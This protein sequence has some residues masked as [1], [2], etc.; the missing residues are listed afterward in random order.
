MDKTRDDSQFHEISFEELEDIVAECA[1]VEVPLESFQEF[2]DETNGYEKDLTDEITER[3]CYCESLVDAGKYTEAFNKA[4]ELHTVLPQQLISRLFKLYDACATHGNIGA[5]AVLADH[6]FCRGESSTEIKGQAFDYLYRLYQKGYLP[7]FRDLGYCY[8]HGIGT[9]IDKKKAIT[10]FTKGFLYCGDHACRQYLQ[11]LVPEIPDAFEDGSRFYL[12][13]GCEQNYEKAFE[14]LTNAAI[15]E[16][17]GAGYCF[18]RM[19]D[20]LRVSK[21]EGGN[22]RKMALLYKSAM[23]EIF[24]DAPEVDANY[25]EGEIYYN[26]GLCYFD[27]YG[28]KQDY[29]KAAWFLDD[30]HYYLDVDDERHMRADELIKEAYA[31]AEKLSNDEELGEYYRQCFEAGDPFIDYDWDDDEEDDYL[32][33]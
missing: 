19:A 23:K 9:S 8:L 13:I 10:V 31:R 17:Y 22:A 12:G 28:V 14:L 30:C 11:E 20:I 32:V 26:I 3:L 18:A 29:Y 5:N 24:I 15:Y 25:N 16:R 7:Y 6:Y 2:V 4:Y 33:L 1:E 27:G 21:I